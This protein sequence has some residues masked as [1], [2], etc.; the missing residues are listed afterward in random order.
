MCVCVTTVKVGFFNVAPVDPVTLQ[1]VLSPHLH[2][3]QTFC[4]YRLYS[5]SVPSGSDGEKT[6]QN[7]I[8]LFPFPVHMT[9]HRPHW[10]SLVPPPHPTP[11][12][13]TPSTAARDYSWRVMVE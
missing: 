4:I 3:Y 6:K 9:S 12:P 2:Q 5:T 11:T 8:Q 1:N 13:L 10:C 7:H